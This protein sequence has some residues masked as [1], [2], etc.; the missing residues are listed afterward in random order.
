MDERTQKIVLGVLLAAM[1]GYLG[2]TFG[3][4]P[5]ADRLQELEARLAALEIDNRTARVLSEQGGE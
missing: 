3:Y 5:R 1:L 4:Q 2:Y